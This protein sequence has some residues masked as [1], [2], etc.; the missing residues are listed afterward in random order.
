MLSFVKDMY[1]SVHKQTIPEDHE[2]DIIYENRG[3]LSKKMNYN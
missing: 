1:L 3:N 2:S